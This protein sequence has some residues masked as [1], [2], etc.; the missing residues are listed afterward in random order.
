MHKRKMHRRRTRREKDAQGK[1]CAGRRMH[2]SRVRG[3]T[4]N[5]FSTIKLTLADKCRE[6]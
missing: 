5:D 4:L 1:G 2:R 6:G 3:E